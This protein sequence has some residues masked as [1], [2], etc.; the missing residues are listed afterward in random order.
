MKGLILKLIAVLL[1]V[2]CGCG[3]KQVVFKPKEEY[4]SLSYEKLKSYSGDELDNAVAE[5]VLWRIGEDSSR[6]KEIVSSL[7]SGVQVIYTTFELE[8]EVMNGGLNQYFW[9]SSGAFAEETVKH[10]KLLGAENHAHLLENA[11]AIRQR[12]KPKMEKY[13]KEGTIDAFSRSYEDTELNDLDTE[14]Y[15]LTDD[16]RVLRVKYVREHPEAFTK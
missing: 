13:K 16:L 11:I 4:K 6:T 1:A 2:F 15:K 5:H 10:L 3:K 14:F 7:P 9:N 8:C 12:E